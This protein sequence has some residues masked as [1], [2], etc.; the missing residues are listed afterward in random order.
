MIDVDVEMLNGENAGQAVHDSLEFRGALLASKSAKHN[1]ELRDTER[2]EESQ[3]RAER[4]STRGFGHFSNA[5]RRWG[6][7]TLNW[8]KRDTKCDVGRFRRN[9]NLGRLKNCE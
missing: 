8:S 5:K 2:E 3:D 9:G 7:R 6:S 4:E 1:N